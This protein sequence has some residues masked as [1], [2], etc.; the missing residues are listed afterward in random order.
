MSGGGDDLA[1]LALAL[2]KRGV[3]ATEILDVMGE[4]GSQTERPKRGKPGPK[5]KGEREP[6]GRSGKRPVNHGHV[7]AVLRDSPEPLT[8]MEIVQ[9][10]PKLTLPAAHRHLY[11]GG[12]IGTVIVVRKEKPQTYVI[13]KA[14]R[15]SATGEVP[16]SEP[17]GEGLSGQL[18]HSQVLSAIGRLR[19]AT[20]ET[21]REA[22]PHATRTAIYQHLVNGVRN[23]ELSRAGKGRQVIFKLKAAGVKAAS[24][25][26]PLAAKPGTRLAKI[27]S[28]L[29]E[30][31]RPMRVRE[32][33]EKTFPEMRLGTVE[34]HILIGHE[35]KILQRDDKRPYS[36]TV[37]PTAA[38]AVAPVRETKPKRTPKGRL[39]GD[40]FLVGL[41]KQT[42][43]LRSKEIYGLFPD[44]LPHSVDT[45]LSNRVKDGSVQRIGKEK[46]YSYQAKPAKP[47]PAATAPA[48]AKSGGHANG[49]PV[50]TA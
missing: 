45:A 18:T 4:P 11:R 15:K 34:Q 20:M 5:P 46:P 22:L 48:P 14:G 19:S 47:A 36:Y 25:P 9:R 6:D 8:A 38:K 17:M 21:L 7:L 13:T 1:T 49:T 24:G 31:G 10:L 16:G 33:W 29:R 42:K 50:A 28:T 39:E 2:L 32:I 26:K 23:G 12:Q 44:V 35:K 40:R 27:V 37:S 3:S 30:A 43:P 41:R